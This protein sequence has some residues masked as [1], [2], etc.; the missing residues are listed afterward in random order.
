M[1]AF[2]PLYI[3]PGTGSMLFS[4]LLGLSATLYFVGKAALIKLKFLIGGK[5]NTVQATSSNAGI[6]LF[7]EGPQYINVFLPVLE[8]FEK[9][10][11]N[12]N[13]YTSV[14]DDPSFN[15]GYT[16]VKS[17]YIGQGNTAIARL[18]FLQADIC[19]MTTPGLDVY[20]SLIH[21]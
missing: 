19:L 3:D 7:C 18:N 1:N 17:E 8:A 9:R 14:Q 15:A 12:V 13:Y 20:L 21:I 4:V 16:Y 6:V 11:V 2:F 5:K 10:K